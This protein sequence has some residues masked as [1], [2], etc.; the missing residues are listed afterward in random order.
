MST[1]PPP[2][3]PP[4][5]PTARVTTRALL[6]VLV[7]GTLVRLA[8]AATIP[9]LDDEAHYWVWSRHLMWGYPDHPPMIAALVWLGT[10]LAGDSVLGVRLMAVLYGTATTLAIYALGSRLFSPRTGL[11][12]ALL[13][14]VIPAFAAGGIMAAPDAPL[15]LYWVL[16]MLFGWMAMAE[17]ARW[18]WPAA[19]VMVGLVIQCKLAGAAIA[20]SLAGLVLAT[21][22]YRRW[23]RTPGPYTTALAGAIVVAPLVWW[24]ATHDWATIRRALVIDAWVHPTGALG[25]VVAFLASQ[26]AYYAPLGFPILAAGLIAAFRFRS[27]ARLRY[28]WWCAV[29]TLTVVLLGSLRALAKPHYTGPAL[30]A[31][32][33]AAAALWTSWRPQRLLRAGLVTSAGMT[34]LVLVSAAVPNPLLRQFH[35]ESR[36]WKAVAREVERVLPSLGPAGETFVLAETYQAGSQLAFAARNRVPIVVPFR[37]FALWEPPETWLNRNGLLVDHL[38]GKAFADLS[39]TFERLEIPY[40]VRVSPGR[41]IRLYPGTR[42]RG[43]VPAP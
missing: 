3:S 32:M 35:D 12:A 10:R 33:L 42:F 24:N 11:R 26:F 17:G 43:F 34:L 23:L 28:L 36:A 16:A 7:V 4:A 41:E 37:G 14:L 9:L 21:P 22:E 38:S 29:P 2:G 39:G 1:V 5:A 18:A 30:T 13:S 20:L 6:A 40:T 19:G 31:G 8:A 27:E 25:N 15:A